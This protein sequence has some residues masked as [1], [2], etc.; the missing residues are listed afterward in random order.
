MR[1]D[2]AGRALSRRSRVRAPSS[3]K[4]SCDYAAQ[5][6]GHRVIA[7]LAQACSLIYRNPEERG[8]LTVAPSCMGP[9]RSVPVQVD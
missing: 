2:H 5:M 7:P 6:M 3:V 1:S 9:S 4:T 8:D